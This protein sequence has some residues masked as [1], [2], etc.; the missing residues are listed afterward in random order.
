MTMHP[1]PAGGMI[2]SDPNN[3]TDYSYTIN[4]KYYVLG[5]YSKSIRPGYKFIHNNN[6]NTL[7][8]YD[9]I[10]AISIDG[11]GETEV[12]FYAATRSDNEFVM[13]HLRCRTARIR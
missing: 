7:T 13:P 6:G 11:G 3:P 9:G 2:Y 12:D 4:Q 5:N 10:A 1:H 8:A